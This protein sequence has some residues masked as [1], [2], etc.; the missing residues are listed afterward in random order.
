[1]SDWEDAIADR[2]GQALADQASSWE[3][4]AAAYESMTDAEAHD[5]WFQ[6]LASPEEVTVRSDQ[7]D[8]ASQARTD[9]YQTGD[10]TA[11]QAAAG[12]WDQ[13]FWSTPA[14]ANADTDAD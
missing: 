7:L 11:W 1:M 4:T 5:S 14:S 3:N 6:A 13:A 9:A 2:A 10:T 8:R 12:D